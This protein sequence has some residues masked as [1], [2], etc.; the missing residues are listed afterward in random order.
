MGKLL[1]R[2]VVSQLVDYL[3]TNMLFEEMQSTYKQNRS[4]QTALLRVYN[5][6]LMSIDDKQCVL[7]VLL[8][9]SAAFDTVDHNILL[10]RLATRFGIQGN[11]LKL[12][13]SYLSE[14]TQY[15]TV[16]GVKSTTRELLWRCLWGLY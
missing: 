16:N 7:L 12:I 1:E 4:P 6:F 13:E 10:S 2:A 3:N 9:L 15:V 8:D 11:V 5:D 14:R